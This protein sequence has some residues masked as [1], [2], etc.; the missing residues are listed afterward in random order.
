[1]LLAPS[2]AHGTF[3]I[4]A[5][6][7]CPPPNSASGRN[8][9]KQQKHRPWAFWPSTNCHRKPSAR[10]PIS[11]NSVVNIQGCSAA[12]RSGC[13]QKNDDQ[14]PRCC[15]RDRRRDKGFCGQR[16]RVQVG[17]SL[18]PGNGSSSRGYFTRAARSKVGG[19]GSR[20]ARHRPQSSARMTTVVF[21][22]DRN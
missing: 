11:L 4:Q 2:G 3:W 1:M 21:D 8:F 12:D 22:H 10:G 14:T 16:I 19:V 13:R 6:H 18:R 5:R 17:H 9:A 15:R 7:H 20:L